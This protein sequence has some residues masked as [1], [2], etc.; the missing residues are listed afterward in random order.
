MVE[1]LNPF[2]TAGNAGPDLGLG[3]DEVPRPEPFFSCARRTL[4]DRFGV[5]IS[6]DLRWKDRFMPFIDIVANR[7]SDQMARDRERR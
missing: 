1:P 6:P 7:L 5:S 3:I 2:T 4:P